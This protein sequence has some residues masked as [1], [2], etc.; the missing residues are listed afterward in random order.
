VTTTIYYGPWQCTAAWMSRCERQCAAQGHLLQG[1]IWLADI[2]GDW[3]GRFLGFPAEAGGRYALTHCCCDYPT[4]DAPSLRRIWN[5]AREGFREGWAEDFGA[6]PQ[7]PNGGPLW[8]GHHIR[9]LL[10]GGHPTAPANI[11]PVPSDVHSV[12]N[13]AYPACYAGDPR[14]KGIGPDRPYAD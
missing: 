3:R 6:W 10:H 2:K 12:Y 1:C 13:S 4:T 9:D 7:Q 14:W 5:N 8:A 11:L